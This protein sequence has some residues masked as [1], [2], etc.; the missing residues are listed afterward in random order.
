VTAP[1]VVSLSVLVALLA[2]TGC[3]A[4]RTQPTA[5][6]GAAS[7]SG[8]AASSATPPVDVPTTKAPT[9]A[10]P[11]APGPGSMDEP[12]T[13]SGP[14]SLASFPTPRRLGTGWAYAVDPGSAEEGYSGNGTSTLA[15]RPEEIVRTAVP[16]GCARTA[17]MPAPDHALEVDYTLR[18]RTAIA[19]LSRFADRARAA[20][21]F[22][23]RGRNLHAC[24]GRSGSAAIG[25]LVTEPRSPMPGVLVSDRTPASDPWREVSVLDGDT[26]VLLAVQGT[27]TLPRTATRRLVR[28]FRS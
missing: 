11:D 8:T 25:A 21:F 7:P 19:V 22:E 1:G 26:V 18:G 9:R 3:S 2:L 6:T 10:T 23:H 13:S 20:T 15:R 5:S 12:A 27:Q 14:L 16:L 4:D 17:A 24:T 28:L